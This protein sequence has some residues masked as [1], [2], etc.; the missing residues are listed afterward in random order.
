MARKFLPS[1][2]KWLDYDWVLS[3]RIYYLG[4]ELNLPLRR[5]AAIAGMSFLLIKL[6]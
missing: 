1:Y 6:D 3:F 2:R 5:H 4:I